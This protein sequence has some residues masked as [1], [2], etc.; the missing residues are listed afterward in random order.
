MKELITEEMA[1]VGFNTVLD[2]IED[3]MSGFDF[4]TSR[5][6]MALWG[7]FHPSTLSSEPLH[8]L[9]SDLRKISNDLNCYR[10]SL[11]EGLKP[12]SLVLHA[13]SEAKR[14]LIEG[15]ATLYAVDVNNAATVEQTLKSLRNLPEYINR[16]L[17]PT[18]A[19]DTIR[20]DSSWDTALVPLHDYSSVLE[21]MEILAKLYFISCN[22]HESVNDKQLL[23]QM[24]KFKEYAI[25]HSSRPPTDLVPYQ[26]LIWFLDCGKS[27]N[28]SLIP[29]LIQDAAYTYHQRLWRSS[30]FQKDLFQLVPN[31]TEKVIC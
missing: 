1:S 2:Q 12:K 26:R 31:D 14:I 7:H 11:E 17:Q 10:F 20:R 13:K 18:E 25:N 23:E 24:S 4:D 29:G 15:I 3:I 5:S 21:E 8:M 30:V 9:E 27:I 6:M 16:E 19:N 22:R 28:T